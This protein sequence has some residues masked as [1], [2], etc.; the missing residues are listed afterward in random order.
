MTYSRP[1]QPRKGPPI[2][3][4]L[5]PPSRHKKPRKLPPELLLCPSC[6]LK[7]S[8]H[9]GAAGLCSALQDARHRLQTIIEGSTEQTLEN[10]QM[11]VLAKG[12][13]QRFNL[14][15]PHPL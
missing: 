14:E 4:S 10:H 15:T 13:F 3:R 11:V 5:P 9:I 6:G 12:H 8:E 2:F 7:W 1:G